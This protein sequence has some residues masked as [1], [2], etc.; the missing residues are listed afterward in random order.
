[1][2]LPLGKNSSLITYKNTVLYASEEGIFK[3]DKNKKQF[4]KDS[5]LSSTIK[6]SDYISGKLVVDKDER[7]WTFSKNNISYIENDDVTNKPVISNIPIPSKLRRGVL[8]Y[9]NISLTNHDK[10]VLGTA[11]G[12]IILDAS[13]INNNKNYTIHLNA[14]SLQNINDETVNYP[15]DIESEKGLVDV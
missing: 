2:T 11:N 6:E 7:L 9:E 13:R 3:Y 5:I 4:Q 1:M 12:Y 14:V 15:L 8:G 10:Y